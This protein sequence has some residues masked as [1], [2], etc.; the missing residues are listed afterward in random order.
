MLTAVFFQA[1]N[2]R[3]KLESERKAEKE[4]GVNPLV[5]PE[6]SKGKEEATFQPA[7]NLQPRSGHQLPKSTISPN[8][9]SSLFV[10]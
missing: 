4:I 10:S 5:E 7:Q 8:L 9:Q 3:L 1:E 2:Q 6:E